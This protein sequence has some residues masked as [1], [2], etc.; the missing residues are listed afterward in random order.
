MALAASPMQKSEERSDMGDRRRAGGRRRRERQLM[1]DGSKD[2]FRCQ[3]LEVL[4]RMVMAEPDQKASSAQKNAI[5]GL[6]L[7]TPDP[8]QII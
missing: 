3:P 5:A 2:L 4:A 7:K 8:A 6:G 1:L